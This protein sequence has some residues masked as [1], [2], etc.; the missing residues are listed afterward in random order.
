MQNPPPSTNGDDGGYAAAG[1]VAVAG[2]AARRGSMRRRQSRRQLSK[3]NLLRNSASSAGN[4]DFAAAAAL[5]AAEDEGIGGVARTSSSSGGGGNPTG[6]MERQDSW[7]Q[8]VLMQGGAEGLGG[9]LGEAMP[10]NVAAN[11]SG[12]PVADDDEVLEQYRIM[13]HVE[14]NIRVKE[15]T[16]FDLAEYEKRRKLHEPVNSGRSTN[17]KKPKAKLPEPKRI[18]SSRS[19]VHLEEPRLPPPRINRK[20]IEQRVESRVPEICPGVIVHGSSTQSPMGEHIVRCLG[21]RSHLR[22]KM[23]ATLVKCP[24]CNT[25]SPA[26]STRR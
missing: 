16:G 3:R 5:V 10:N 2:G 17:Q 19:N 8:D 9:I 23:L 20:Y 14:A 6:R 1:G 24:E 4:N 22:V 25:L 7:Y 21:C 15:N 18:T 26:S 12:P 11:A 13:A